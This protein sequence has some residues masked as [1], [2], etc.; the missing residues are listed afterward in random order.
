M[1]S[2]GPFYRWAAGA[3]MDSRKEKAMRELAPNQFAIGISGGD[4]AMIH[5]C[6]RDAAENPELVFMSPDV[7]NA[8]CE[9]DREEC[10]EDMTYVI[11]F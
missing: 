5:A 7:K 4:E 11:R 2:P 10:I 9:L 8:Y 1:G 6:S 3:I